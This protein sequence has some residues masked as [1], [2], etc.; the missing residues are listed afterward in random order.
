MRMRL[1][2]HGLVVLPCASLRHLQRCGNAF[3]PQVYCPGG[4]ETGCHPGGPLC[5]DRCSSGET[6]PDC[7]DIDQ[8]HRGRPSIR[9]PTFMAWCTSLLHGIPPPRFP[10]SPPSLRR[11]RGGHR[12]DPPTAWHGAPRSWC[13]RGASSCGMPSF[14]VF[15]SNPGRGYS[16]GSCYARPLAGAV[17]GTVPVPTSSYRWPCR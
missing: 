3:N 7:F 14:H 12:S 5:A 8:D 17:V 1:C 10:P 4:N 11:L 9:F 2:R 16:C 13:P 15:F 6:V